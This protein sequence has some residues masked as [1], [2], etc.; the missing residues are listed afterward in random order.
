MLSTTIFSLFLFFHGLLL[1]FTGFTR[2]PLPDIFSELY[3]LGFL[4]KIKV[5]IGMSLY[6]P[7]DTVLPE[8]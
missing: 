8:E 3:A 7:T 1:L 2:T 4:I 6:T 5:L